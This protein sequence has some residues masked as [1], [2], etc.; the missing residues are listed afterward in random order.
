MTS[1][2]SRQRARERSTDA[3]LKMR[4]ASK[5]RE[6]RDALIATGFVA[7][8]VQAQALGVSRSTAWNILNGTY[9]SSGL[10]V[11]II[12]RMLAAPRLPPLVRTKIL[13]YIREKTAGCYGHGNIQLRK[14]SSRLV[15]S[16]LRQD[17]VGAEKRNESKLFSS[18][19]R[20]RRQP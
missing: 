13:E 5:I 6:I 12:N 8:D 15:T 1:V 19:S 4:Q 2:P 18:R 9:K 7:L 16:H 11:A 14:F 17:D 20:S 10:S 3:E